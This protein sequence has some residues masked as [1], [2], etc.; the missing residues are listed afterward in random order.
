M[1]DN[2]PSTFE[3][4]FAEVP[5]NNQDAGSRIADPEG[6]EAESRRLRLNQDDDV[7][8]DFNR[9]RMYENVATETLPFRRN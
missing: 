6:L 9:G 8:D 3:A 5:T 7:N 1:D 2:Q 4:A